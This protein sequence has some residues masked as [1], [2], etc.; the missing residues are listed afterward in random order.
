MFSLELKNVLQKLDGLPVKNFLTLLTFGCLVIFLW[1]PNA[2]N[3]QYYIVVGNTIL[4]IL[5][6]EI[7]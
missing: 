7:S 3:G 2:G 6:N 1:L 5:K 4:P